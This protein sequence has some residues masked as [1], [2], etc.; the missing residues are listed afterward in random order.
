M[1]TL[2][3][4]V[5]VVTGAASGIGRGLAGRFAAEG[6]RVVLAD[7]EEP[8]LARAVDE[9]RADGAE[10]VGVPTDVSQPASVEALA[11][12]AFDTY[13]A[14]HVVCNNAGV[15]AV[16]DWGALR[17][18]GAPAPLWEHDLESWHWTFGVNFWGVVHGVRT[19]VPRLLDQG[20]QAHIVNTGSVLGFHGGPDLAIY[21]A[22]KFAV[23]RLS[24][25][26]H[27]Q[28][29]QLDAPIHV[30]V[31][32][33]GM[34]HTRSYDAE[35]NRPAAL[36]GALSG[37]LAATP[38]ATLAA[39]LD[40]TPEAEPEAEP[41]YRERQR[42]VERRAA[43][44]G[45]TPAEVAAHVVEAIHE[46]RFYVFTHDDADAPIRERV[47]RILERRNPDE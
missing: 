19:F 4:K 36:S 35:R 37:T 3:G 28:L 25:A 1:Q 16:S 13:G 11:D 26:L 29:R 47:Q 40:A 10:A 21:G 15:A 33:P 9:L 45:M 44:D 2:E 46:R 24:E 27:L 42:A 38:D 14:V 34:V 5:A 17:P 7:I 32:C 39:T 8:A 31:L 41:G 22:T 43:A 20:E 23:V 30:S 12:S 6:M 18:G